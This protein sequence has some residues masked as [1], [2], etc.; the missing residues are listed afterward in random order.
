M[1]NVLKLIYGWAL[2]L[3]TFQM[4]FLFG[5]KRKETITEFYRDMSALCCNIY[6]KYFKKKIGGIGLTIEIDESKFTKRKY[7]VGR[8]VRDLWV[9]GGICRETN[10]VFFVIVEDRS[11]E[12][13][14]E[15]IME[16]VELGSTIYTDCWRGYLNLNS[17]GY[18]HYTVNHSRN[19]VDP[20][21][22]VH[23]QTIEST[24][25]ALKRFLR[26]HNICNRSSLNNIFSEFI[27]KRIFKYEVFN[28]FL[29]FANIY[30]ND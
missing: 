9:V 22:A 10:D 30:S 17:Y 27:F 20:E 21:T 7:N 6:N 24:W 16:N 29:I 26:R 25:G 18:I 12:T 4:A 5:F 28:L 13:L 8:V 14:L 11:E 3:N 19:F 15:V 2:R 1:A 23:T